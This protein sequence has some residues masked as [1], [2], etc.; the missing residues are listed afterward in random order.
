MPILT[1]IMSAPA[2]GPSFSLA[3]ARAL[4]RD[5]FAHDERIYW[6]DFLATMLIGYSFAGATRLLYEIHLQPLELRLLLQA[7]TFSV[8]CVCFFRGVMFVHEIVHLPD[9]KFRAFRTAWNLLCGIPFLLPSF[10]YY[11]HLD[12]HRRQMFGTKE[13]GEYLPLARMSPWWIVVYLSQC[14]WIPP[15]AV[16]RFGILTPLTWVCP[17]QRRL[18]HQRL[19][20]LVMDPTY[21]R[22]LPTKT[23]LFYIRIQELGCFLLI[24]GCVVWARLLLHRWPLP[25][26]IHGYA[27]AVVLI[28]L[29]AMRTLAAH[30]WMSEGREVSFVDQ[31]LDSVTLDSDSLAAILINPVG[32]RYHATHHLFPSLPY[33]N[34]RTAHRRLMENL[35]ADSPYRLTVEHSLWKVVTQLWK[36]AANASSPS[37]YGPP[38]PHSGRAWQRRGRSLA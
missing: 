8:Q 24:W 11:T 16:L 15:V 33:H 23:A 32:L 36:R 3:Q 30:R 20:S 12:H 13:D 38:A 4:V 37:R 28:L 14:L 25:L 29:N 9:R 10:T 6:L 21:L 22:P 35:P 5:L 18:I 17:P 31:M 34:I 2:T 26:M 1:R 27:T 7:C 19:S